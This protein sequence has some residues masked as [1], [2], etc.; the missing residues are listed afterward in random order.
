M[1]YGATTIGELK[2]KIAQRLGRYR[3]SFV[4]FQGKDANDDLISG[5]LEKTVK[6]KFKFPVSG[7]FT[8][9][10]LRSGVDDLYA[11]GLP[12]TIY[13]KNACFGDLKNV[14]STMRGQVVLPTGI[15]SH[16]KSTFTDWYVLNL[17]KDYS[18]KASWYTP[19]HSPMNLYETELIQKTIGRNFWK[20]KDGQPRISKEDIDQYDEWANEKI[21]LTDCGY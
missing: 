19:E 9:K 13:P 14:F 2:N 11:N 8:A 3:C 6:S 16:G 10:D 21:Y 18:M 7:T 5:V 20:E 1:K 12:E 4:E 17:I 15:P